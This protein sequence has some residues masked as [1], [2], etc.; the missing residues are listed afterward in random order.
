MSWILVQSQLGPDG[1]G[2]NSSTTISLSFN[3]PVKPGSIICGMV[4]S[5]TGDVL[6]SVT[7]DKGNSYT[8]TPVMTDAPLLQQYYG[9]F[10]IGPTNTPTTI[11]ATFNSPL[12]WLR[13]GLNEF[14]GGISAD[15]NAGQYNSTPAITQSSGPLTTTGNGDLVYGFGGAS[16]GPGAAFSAGANFTISNVSNSNDSVNIADE[17][18]VQQAAGP[19]SA[20]FSLSRADTCCVG[21]MAFKAAPSSAPA[22]STQNVV[23]AIPVNAID[24]PPEGQR[25]AKI[26]ATLTPIAFYSA[27]QFQLNSQSGLTLSQVC[28][29]VIDNSQ[30]NAPIAIVHGALN[31]QVLVPANTTTI[32]PTFSTKGYY[33]LS[34]GAILPPTQNLVIPIT[35]LNYPRQGGQFSS[36]QNVNVQNASAIDITVGGP[37]PITIQNTVLNTG[38]N[39]SILLSIY[40]SSAAVGTVS[41]GTAATKNWTLDSLDFA[42]EF[43]QG[44]AAGLA[45]AGIQVLVGGIAVHSCYPV[46]PFAAAGY[47][48]GSVNMATHR[49]W[50]Q[51]MTLNGV[52]AIQV[53]TASLSNLTSVGY[54]LNISGWK[55]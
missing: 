18:L 45:Q 51:G 39:S 42:I 31:Q 5:N 32:V 35:L 12:T 22:T 1:V 6:N 17:W 48:Q 34:V 13:L 41:Y 11:T 7:D 20:T 49:T 23:A 10:C 27:Q 38:H 55:Q 28:T 36:Q 15:G 19:I 26:V 9:F 47:I 8:L 24:P 21:V 33:F 30:N 40:N 3:A 4:S 29:L 46:Y 44:T 14:S 54:R 25:A 50:P 52:T 43:L 53:K 16:Q 37:T 2:S